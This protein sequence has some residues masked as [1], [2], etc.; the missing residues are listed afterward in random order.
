M[1]IKR[2]IVSLRY[3]YFTLQ[4]LIFHETDITPL[5]RLPSENCRRR[6]YS[7]FLVTVFFAHPSPDIP[8]KHNIKETDSKRNIW[9]QFYIPYGEGEGGG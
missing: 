4:P 7:A 9:G 3:L 2:G 1:S 5:A 8:I 6:A